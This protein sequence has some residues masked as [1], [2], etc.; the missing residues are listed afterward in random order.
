MSLL[1]SHLQADT[2][3][4]HS[5]T[6]KLR[7]DTCQSAKIPWLAEKQPLE[8]T[9]SIFIKVEKREYVMEYVV[10]DI[11]FFYL[12]EAPNS[13]YGALGNLEYEAR[14]QHSRVLLMPSA[15][16]NPKLIKLGIKKN[17]ARNLD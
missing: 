11:L 3:N 16:S 4:Q 14:E 6:K 7:C 1:N 5:D 9:S 10:L 13:D 15:M 8:K 2:F 17:K 12:S